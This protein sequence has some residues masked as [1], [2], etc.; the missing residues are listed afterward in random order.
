MQS[1]STSDERT[2]A[3]GAIRNLAHGNAP[4]RKVMAVAID[5]LVKVQ[6]AAPVGSKEREQSIGALWNLAWKNTANKKAITDAGGE[7]VKP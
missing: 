3:V 4:N 7:L 2:E 6:K 5:V 1:E